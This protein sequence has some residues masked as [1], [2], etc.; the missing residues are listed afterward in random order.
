[1]IAVY[2]TCEPMSGLIPTTLYCK[3]ARGTHT[4]MAAVH[5]ADQFRGSTNLDPRMMLCLLP[6]SHGEC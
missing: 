3:L 2:Y 4:M 5:T 1:M 6:R